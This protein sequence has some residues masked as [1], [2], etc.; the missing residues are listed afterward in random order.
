MPMKMMKKYSFFYIAKCLLCAS[1]LL[2]YFGGQKMSRN[3]IIIKR[4][5]CIFIGARIL[6]I[7]ISRNALFFFLHLFFQI[8]FSFA[9][10]SWIISFCS[11][12]CSCMCKTVA[13]FS[14]FA[15]KA[16]SAAVECLFYA[17]LRKIVR[18]HTVQLYTIKVACI[19]QKCMS[20]ALLYL[21]RTVGLTIAH[22]PNR[23][24]EWKRSLELIFFFF[25]K[26]K[27]TFSFKRRVTDTKYGD[28]M[29]SLN[30][31]AKLMRSFFMKLKL[32][33]KFKSYC[34]FFEIRPVYSVSLDAELVVLSTI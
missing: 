2:A 9:L 32:W 28:Q 6:L 25:E 11:G 22:C 4:V 17:N 7:I 31:N 15:H 23:T 13:L 34:T 33:E 12:C 16:R 21:N 1:M 8:R 5:L 3:W 24:F 10:S 18:A 26:L 14:S 30:Y 29:I 19:M 20:L 27:I